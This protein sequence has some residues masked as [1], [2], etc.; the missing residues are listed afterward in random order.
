VH[1]VSGL[2][3]LGLSDGPASQVP[4]NGLGGFQQL[5]GYG[6]FQVSGQQVALARMGYQVRLA[7]APLT[8][9]TFLGVSLEAGQAWD[10]LKEF[11][12]VRTRAGASLY[13]GADTALGPVY[14]AVLHSPRVGPTVMLFV[15]RP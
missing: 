7:A 1:T 12:S 4:R 5:S 3:R 14:G 15:G 10:R 11:G 6:P 13:L 8:R 2:A 9:G